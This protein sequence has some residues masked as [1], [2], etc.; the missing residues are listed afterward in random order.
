MKCTS[1]F[2][3]IYSLIMTSASAAGN[4]VGNGADVLVCENKKD[5]LVDLF[6]R[7]ERFGMKAVREERPTGYSPVSYLQSILREQLQDLDPERYLRLARQADEFWSETKRLSNPI[8]IDIDD[9]GVIFLPYGCHL[10]QLFVQ[11]VPTFTS[12][13]RYY[14]NLDRFDNLSLENQ[15]AAI[16]HELLYRE[17]IPFSPDNSIPIR[18]LTALIF[19]NDLNEYSGER[20]RTLISRLG[21]DTTVLKG[22]RQP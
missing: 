15:S 18:T 2:V 22:V 3:L 7:D 6:E 13:A 16:L 20:Y 5:V 21:F 14:V 17:L 9:A 10:E 19:S 11:I 12:E 8:L 4:R 1:S